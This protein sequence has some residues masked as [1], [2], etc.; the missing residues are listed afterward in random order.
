VSDSAKT[1]QS[2]LDPRYVA[3]RRVLLDA[4]VALEPHQH[5]V[6]VAGAQAIY[7]R[8]GS[9]DVG[10]APFTI[11]DDPKLEDAM[12]GAGFHLL[13]QGDNHVEPGIWV[14][15]TKAGSIDIQIP[16]DLIVPEGFAP[17]GGRRGARLGLHGNR[18]ARRVVGLE[19][20]LV[21]HDRITI[22]ALES[23][24]NR[25]IPVEVAGPAALLISKIHKLH[26]RA[27]RG[28][29]DRLTDKDAADVVRVMQ[30]T[31][32]YDVGATVLSLY[33]HEVA[34]PVARAAVEYMAAL[35]GRR[36][37]PGI[38]MASRTLRVA[39]PAERV[40][41]ICIS[42]TSILTATILEGS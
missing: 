29:P 15:Q 32:P 20:A 26:D 41:A 23:S 17:S 30:A 31:S 9:A 40:E 6:V 39:I 22:E 27:D 18:A 4:L 12:T 16:V 2:R 10:I 19:A 11:D 1:S 24:D 42:Y 3:A 13:P 28:R 35:F 37:Q 34:S 38:E 36:G 7:I 25:S 5:A 21:D 8:T 14:A 33:K